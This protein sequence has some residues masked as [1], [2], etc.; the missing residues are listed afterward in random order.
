MLYVIVK[1]YPG[2]SEE[3][4]AKR[5]EKIVEDVVTIGK[6]EEKSVSQ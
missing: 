5:A 6:C 2:R 4:K 1:M 3:Q